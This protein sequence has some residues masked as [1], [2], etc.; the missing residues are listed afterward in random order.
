MYQNIHSFSGNVGLLRTAF[1]WSELYAL[2]LAFNCFICIMKLCRFL[3]FN[4]HLS[5]LAATLKHIAVQVSSFSIIILVVICAY[6]LVARIVFYGEAQFG[7]VGSS[8]LTLFEMTV[9]GISH[10]STFTNANSF[11]SRLYFLSFNCLMAFI[12]MNLFITM[13]SETYAFINKHKDTYSY[14]KE[15]VDFMWNKF[16]DLWDTTPGSKRSEPN[17]RFDG[18]PKELGA[19]TH[20]DATS[21]ELRACTHTDGP[22][23]SDQKRSFDGTPRGH[24]AGT[25]VGLLTSFELYAPTFESHV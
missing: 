22:S 4:R 20:V 15:L 13:I 12:F 8:L 19:G 10:K 16:K 11:A 6:V 23:R 18:T 9:G 2:L 17:E 1:F 5:M 7:T 21:K 24:R 14:D 25:P 3:Q